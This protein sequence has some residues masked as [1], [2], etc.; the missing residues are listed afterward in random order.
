MITESLRKE[1]EKM[2]YPMIECKGPFGTYYREMS[3]EEYKARFYGIETTY[4][5]DIA[6]LRRIKEYTSYLSRWFS[7]N[8]CDGFPDFRTRYTSHVVPMSYNIYFNG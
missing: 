7:H 4:R 1:E 5:G 8:Y 6:A 2:E 3:P